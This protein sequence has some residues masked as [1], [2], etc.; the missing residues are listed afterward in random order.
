MSIEDMRERL[1]KIDDRVKERKMPVLLSRLRRSY[2]EYNK[3]DGDI[4]KA[5]HAIDEALKPELKHPNPP[6]M[7]AC[8]ADLLPGKRSLTPLDNSVSGDGTGGLICRV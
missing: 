4:V 7:M 5:A 1:R 3:D 2:H 8:E 6:A